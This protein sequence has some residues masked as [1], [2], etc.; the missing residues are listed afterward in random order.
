MTHPLRRQPL[1]EQTAT[2]LREGLQSGRWSGQLPGVPQLVNDL[3]VSK[4]IIRAALRVLE[5]EGLIEDCGAGR[6]RRIV[7]Q[8]NATPAHRSLRIGVMQYVPL[9]EEDV[10]TTTVLLDVRHQIEMAGHI[11]VFSER[12]MTQ[13][14]DNLTSISRYVKTVAAD[15]WIVIAASRGVLEWFASQS[16]PVFAYGGRFQNLPVASSGLRIAPAIESAVNALT[17]YGHRRIVL[18]IE[19]S[20]RKP[21]LIPSLENYLS[22]LEARGIATTDYNLPHFEDTAEGLDNCLNGLFRIT[23]PTALIV[24]QAHQCAAVISFLGRRGLRVPQDVSIVCMSMDPVFNWC[25]PPLN[26]FQA[27][28]KKHVARIVRW[29]DGVAKGSPDKRQVTFDAVYI[30]GGTVGP[31]KK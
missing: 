25:L 3:V 14:K 11:C 28:Q 26:Y 21:T 7:P 12:Y 8:Q 9:M 4:H 5:K 10:L 19:T 1:V 29:V 18:L 13:M 15:A 24:H 30:P 27:P 31:V 16:F 20:L 17:E 2:H 23:P 22:F 6:R